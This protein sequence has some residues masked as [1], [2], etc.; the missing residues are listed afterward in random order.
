MWNIKIMFNEINLGNILP[1]IINPSHGQQTTAD[2]HVETHESFHD[3]F[4]FCSFA[5][6]QT[7]IPPVQMTISGS[8]RRQ[9][10]D[11]ILRLL[12]NIPETNTS[13]T[14]SLSNLRIAFRQGFG[15]GQTA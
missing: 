15:R 12:A 14:T 5:D 13:L 6:D 8:Q 11:A 7:P 9:I 10:E 3:S 2:S 4:E 1:T